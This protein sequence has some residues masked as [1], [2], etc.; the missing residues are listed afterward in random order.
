[1]VRGIRDLR[2]EHSPVI[3]T[4]VT[5]MVDNSRRRNACVI[6]GAGEAGASPTD[7]RPISQHEL[8]FLTVAALEL[9]TVANRFGR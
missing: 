4:T 5:A 9:R 1:M 3:A 6:V 8:D 2:P 7:A